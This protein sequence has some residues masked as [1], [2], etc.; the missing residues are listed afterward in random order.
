MNGIVAL[1]LAFFLCDLTVT[2]GVPDGSL[3]LN[4]ELAEIRRYVAEMK[5]NYDRQ[6]LKSEVRVF[7]DFESYVVLMI[8]ILFFFYQINN[9]NQKHLKKNFNG[10]RHFQ[11]KKDLLQ[12]SVNCFFLIGR[13]IFLS[14]SYE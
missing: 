11:D 6:Q 3:P 7:F 5:K 12:V 14:H 2:F 8:P 1:C 10:V 13:L 9:K 4:D